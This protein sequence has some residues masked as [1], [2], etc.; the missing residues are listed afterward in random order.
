V[1]A[2][3]VVLAVTLVSLVA[4]FIGA[5]RRER[6]AAAA[7]P[8]VRGEKWRVGIA[9]A[10]GLIL[11]VPPIVEQ[12]TAP[13]GNFRRIVTFFVHREAPL[14]PLLTATREWMTMMAWLPYRVGRLSLLHD[15]F[16]PY[17]ASPHEMYLGATSFPF[18]VAGMHVA[19]GIFCGIV[20]W[21]RTDVVSLALLATGALADL[22]SIGVL[23][24]VVG[25]SAPYLVL[26]TSA[27]SSLLWIGV[28]STLFSAM[29]AAALKS[30][31]FVNTA[32][33]PIIVVGLTLAVATATVQRWGFAKH[34]A[35]LGS[36]PELRP[37]IEKAYAALRDRLRADG[38]TPV[39]HLESFRD[40]A[41]GFYLELEK[42]R[43]DVRTPDRALLVGARGEE[44]AQKPL[45][46]WIA[47]AAAPHRLAPC[48][49][50]I[51]KSGD[52]VVLGSP[53]APAACP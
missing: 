48:T 47:S 31:R 43:L 5:R 44:R 21:K 14:V 19:L 27:G 17:L 46:L 4:F 49:E 6:D 8:E 23:Q 1:C 38:N 53:T 3:P 2:V 52:L 40:I 15:D 11:A 33:T 32:A 16:V 9:A 50:V 36:H 30:D 18:I 51:A 20:A 35:G 42:D 37:D 39:L 12:I 24:A 45:H 26:W 25:V 13:T 28:L 7:A 29:G 22:V 34:P 41:L 10:I